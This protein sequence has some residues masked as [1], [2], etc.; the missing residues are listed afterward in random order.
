MFS[1]TE[2]HKLLECLYFD[3]YADSYAEVEQLLWENHT[4]EEIEELCESIRKSGL[5]RPTKLPRSRERDIGRHDDWKDRPSEDWNDRPE[6]GKKLRRRLIATVGTR[7]REDEETGIREEVIDYLISEGYADSYESAI[8][9]YENMS[10]DWLE[11]AREATRATTR[12]RRVPGGAQRAAARED[13]KEAAR[14]RIAA[15]KAAEEAKRREEREYVETRRQ[16]PQILRK[17][18]LKRTLASRMSAAAERQ[19]FNE[20][21]KD[22]TPEKEKRVKNRMGELARDI[23]LNF[24]RSKELDKE[25][26]SKFRPGIQKQKS[27]IA[28]N[29]RKKLKLFQNAR[30]AVVPTSVGRQASIQYKIN[31]LRQKLKDLGE[32]D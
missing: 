16:N 11:E 17:E 2:Y 24:A 29:V 8:E 30:D 32:E 27:A 3:E 12:G 19:G 22:L 28:K 20:D 7:R 18:A 25:P 23:Q 9:I 26:L 1:R 21:F 6:A 5:V 13:R 14:E 15:R 10:Y 4:E 31:Q